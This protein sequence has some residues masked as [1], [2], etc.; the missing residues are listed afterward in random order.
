LFLD[1]L[2]RRYEIYRHTFSLRAR[3]PYSSTQRLVP[4]AQIV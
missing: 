4:P 3:Q 2:A 1:L